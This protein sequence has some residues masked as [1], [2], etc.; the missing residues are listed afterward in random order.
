MYNLLADDFPT[1]TFAT[2]ANIASAN[3][4]VLLGDAKTTQYITDMLTITAVSAENILMLLENYFGGANFTLTNIG[5]IPL[6]N[7]WG[8]WSGVQSGRQGG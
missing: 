1:T 4:S 6:E 7:R 3:N 5:S 8:D 2:V